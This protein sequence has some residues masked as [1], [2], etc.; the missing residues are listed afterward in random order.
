MIRE[1]CMMGRNNRGHNSARLVVVDL[2]PA[3]IV[4]IDKNIQ[5]EYDLN[6]D[7]LK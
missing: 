7:L 3:K 2:Y 5:K 4:A 6:D 1:P